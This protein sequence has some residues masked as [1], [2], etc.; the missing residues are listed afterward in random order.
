MMVDP[1][2]PDAAVFQGT[3]VRVGRLLAPRDVGDPELGVVG[4]AQCQPLQ[5]PVDLAVAREVRD[6]LGAVA[7][8]AGNGRGGRDA[9]EAVRPM[10]DDVYALGHSGASNRGR[11][12]AFRLRTCR[13]AV[14]RRRPSWG[15]R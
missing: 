11:G 1:V 8:V 9:V 15:S 12:S 2:E 13:S 6:H 14:A 5:H 3:Q 4:V 10:T 7:V